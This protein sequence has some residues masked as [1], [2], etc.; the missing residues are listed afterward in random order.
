AGAARMGWPLDLS[1]W[2]VAEELER[3]GELPHGPA[4][5]TVVQPGTPAAAA[6]DVAKPA[7]ATPTFKEVAAPARPAQPAPGDLPATGK[8]IGELSL[9]VRKAGTSISAAMQKHGW[10]GNVLT[11]STA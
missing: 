6:A 11:V 4:A 8:M 2:Y 7:G 5:T 9:A 1:T 3:G 10:A